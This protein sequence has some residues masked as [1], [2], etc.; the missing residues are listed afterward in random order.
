MHPTDHLES[1]PFFLVIPSEITAVF[2][3]RNAEFLPSLRVMGQLMELEMELE[4]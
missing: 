4:G 2:A 1:P 3:T